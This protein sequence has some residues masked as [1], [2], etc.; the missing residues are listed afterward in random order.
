MVFRHLVTACPS[1]DPTALQTQ[2]I[3]ITTSWSDPG[4]TERQSRVDHI[5]LA[6]AMP[7]QISYP[8]LKTSAILAFG[9]ALSSLTPSRF[10]DACSKLTAA[11]TALSAQNPGAQMD[12][13]LDSI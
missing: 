1:L 11:R 4:F 12:P 3:D 9:G 6:A 10:K 7:G 13:E 5:T 8:M 2:T